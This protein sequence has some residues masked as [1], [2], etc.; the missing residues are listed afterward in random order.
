MAR[1]SPG[2]F[3]LVL[4]AGC[5]I[6]SGL[7]QAGFVLIVGRIATLLAGSD[8][9]MAAADSLG[10]GPSFIV[11]G[12]LI[13]ALL[14]S[15]VTAA[16][17]SAKILAQSSHRARIALMRR[18]LHSS[19]D[20]QSQERSGELQEVINGHVN[21]IATSINALAVA[22]MAATNLIAML[23]GAAIISPWGALA[24]LVMGI[25]V[26]LTM[27]PALSRMT[28]YA[29]LR[30]R[31]QVELGA[32]INET[33][34][35]SR[36]VAVFG[37]ADAFDDAL[38]N[39]VQAV[40]T[41]LFRGFILRNLVP[42]IFQVSVFAMMLA[43][44]GAVWWLDVSNLAVL[45]VVMAILL[46]AMTYGREL[47]R[48]I[49]SVTE[50]QPYIDAYEERLH[51]F[52]DSRIRHGDVALGAISMLA[53]DNVSYAYP[54]TEGPAISGI[55]FVANRGE[56][57]GITGPS[58]SGKSTLLELLLRLRTGQGRFLINGQPISDFDLESWHQRV[59]YVP[60]RTYVLHGTIADNIRF[61]RDDITDEQIHEA[62]TLAEIHDDIAALPSGYAT[63]LGGLEG[64]M[65][66]GQLQR[67]AI[68][69]ALAGKPE[70]IIFDEPTSALDAVSEARVQTVLT[71]LRGHTTTFVVTHRP[72]L[73]EH[74]DQQLVMANGTLTTQAVAPAV[75]A[76][77]G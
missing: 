59:A 77:H 33:V 7:G 24:L 27:R 68:A 23:I 65:S 51:R 18:F 63:V 74:C 20:V 3:L 64:E 13:G 60:Q 76:S 35:L 2:K 37:V 32:R 16:W 70:L 21:Q 53:M 10:L 49:V 44:L 25:P 19:W 26:V 38:A 15:F 29:R 40:T 11:G 4:V 34:S 57:V 55:T 1:Y 9:D 46:R 73:V 50:V 30:S 75:P 69:R 36:D 41:P 5:G 31:S 6:V 8:A 62:A 47:Q 58:G 61:R 14:A 71:N 67:L 72:A 43:A 28:D 45:G 66:G 54:D 42:Y 22:I 39:D 12:L 17:A 52:G 56:A 48:S